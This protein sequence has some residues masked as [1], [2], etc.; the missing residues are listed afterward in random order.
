MKKLSIAIPTYSFNGFG[1][2][3]LEF[4][5]QKM[6]TQ[7][8]KDFQ[9]CVSDNSD[10]FETQK[11][12]EKWSDILDIKYY[13]NPE[14]GAATNTNKAIEICDAP[15]VKVLCADDYLYDNDSLLHIYEGIEK[16]TAWLFTEYFHTTNRINYY[17]HFIPSM[18]P[19]IALTNTLG[20]PSAMCIRKELSVLFDTNLKYYYD[21]EFYLR[22][23]HTFGPPKI[24]PFVT[25]A[26]YIWEE[27]QTSQTTVEMMKSEVQYILKKYGVK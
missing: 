10:D 1:A 14:K 9:V 17:R 4:S 15:F 16:N 21:S 24:L 8:F 6:R 25:M 11:V 13:R 18:N 12:C 3:L 7:R 27:S 23:A 19:N 26:N 22:M 2:S 5:F 20:T